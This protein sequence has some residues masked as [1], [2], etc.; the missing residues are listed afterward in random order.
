MIMAAVTL[1]AIKIGEVMFGFTK[2]ETI[3]IAALVTTVYSMLGGYLGVL[4]TDFFQFFIAMIGAF[5]AAY[6]AL[7]HEKVG[8]LANLRA[9]RNWPISWH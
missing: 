3:T 4:I 5:A 1:A 7:G 2:L 9:K 8:G 6:F